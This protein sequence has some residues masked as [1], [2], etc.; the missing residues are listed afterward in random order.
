MGYALSQRIV[1][2]T[3][4]ERTGV[5]DPSPSAQWAMAR[6]RVWS[7]HDLPQLSKLSTTKHGE[8]LAA[9]EILIPSKTRCVT[10]F[11]FSQWEIIR[12]IIWTVEPLARV[13]MNLCIHFRTGHDWGN[14]PG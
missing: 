6:S 5:P 2:F 9:L 13:E 4:P 12:G 1:H 8:T 3:L 10:I 11:F 7:L 14:L